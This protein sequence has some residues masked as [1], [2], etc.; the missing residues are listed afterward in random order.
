MVFGQQR[1]FDPPLLISITITDLLDWT[2][3]VRP[4]VLSFFETGAEWGSGSIGKAVTSDTRDPQFKSNN[5]HNL[6]TNCTLEKTKKEKEAGNGPSLKKS[7]FE[8]MKWRYFVTTR[9]RAH[10][11]RSKRTINRCLASLA[12]QVRF[13]ELNLSQLRLTVI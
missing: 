7:I 5:R 12:F 11:P 13:H 10:R 8:I 4:E 2:S 1:S 9:W 3:L 6:S